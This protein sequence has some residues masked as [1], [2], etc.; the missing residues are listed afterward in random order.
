MGC[1]GT[2]DGLY[3]FTIFWHR[4]LN[5]KYTRLLSVG[6]AALLLHHIIMYFQVTQGLP[7][8]RLYL[9][10][11]LRT[12]GYAIFFSTMTLYLKDLIEFPT[13][14]MA[15]TVSGFI[16]MAVSVKVCVRVSMA[17]ASATN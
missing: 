3:P 17:M 2:K 11:F 5:Q 4:P 12:F 8:E 7:I 16:R 13:F 6:F 9:P 15:L 1:I 10:T 14:L